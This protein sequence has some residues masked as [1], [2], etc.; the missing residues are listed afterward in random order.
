MKTEIWNGSKIELWEFLNVVEELTDGEYLDITKTLANHKVN[1]ALFSPLYELDDGR[2]LGKT[3]WFEI[4]D[5]NVEKPFPVFVDVRKVYGINSAEEYTAIIHSEEEHDSLNSDGGTQ[6]VYIIESPF[7]KAYKIGR[8]NNIERRFK[9]ISA[10]SP[11]ALELYGV[12]KTD[13]YCKLESE[14]HERL[15]KYRLHGEWFAL[16]EGILMELQDKY[17]LDLSVSKTIYAGIK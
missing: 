6:G 4:D 9:S 2:L 14:L 3:M 11:V 17:G 16:N 1:Q 5:I 12:I 8:S 7:N 13:N 10:M 15:S